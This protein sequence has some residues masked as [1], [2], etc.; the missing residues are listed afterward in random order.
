[1]I[2]PA[3]RA[4]APVVLAYALLLAAWELAGTL[5]H[6]PKYVLPAPSAFVA[7][8]AKHPGVLAANGTPRAV[9]AAT[10]CAA[11]CRWRSR[12]ASTA[13]SW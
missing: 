2:A 6:V 12:A 8:L 5:F 1:M 7:S 3:V 11:R 9:K 4:Y 13:R 10:T